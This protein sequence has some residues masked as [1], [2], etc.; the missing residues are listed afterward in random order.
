MKFYSTSFPAPSPHRLPQRREKF[1]SVAM[2][3]GLLI[4]DWLI[5]AISGLGLGIALVIIS[6]LTAMM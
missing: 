3:G 1:R 2:A 6:V 5:M 4:L